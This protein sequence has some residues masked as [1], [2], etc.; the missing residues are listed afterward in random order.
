[1]G[2]DSE[3]SSQTLELSAQLQIRID[4][5]LLFLL[6]GYLIRRQSD[7]ATLQVALGGA[8]FE[9]LGRL[10]HNIKG[11]GPGYGLHPLGPLGARLEEAARAGALDEAARIVAEVGDYLARVNSLLTTQA[12]GAPGE[13]LVAAPSL[14]R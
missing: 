12:S 9:A 6:P 1:M 7:L 5:D 3:H 13:A 4:P 10:G 2:A 11:S 8:D 14:P